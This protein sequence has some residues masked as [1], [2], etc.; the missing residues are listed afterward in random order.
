MRAARGFL[1]DRVLAICLLIACA[2][3]ARGQAAGGSPP[4]GSFSLRMAAVSLERA[5]F[6]LISWLLVLVARFSLESLIPISVLRLALVPLF[7]ITSL[8]VTFYILRRVISGHGQL[9]GMLVLVEK[10]LTT[11]CGSPWVCTCLA[12]CR[13]WSH[14]CGTCGSRLAASSTSTWPIR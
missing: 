8:Y 4:V 10:V 7:G 1:A 11:L 6:P 14:G 5:V 3:A 12:C 2:V 9:H 13:T